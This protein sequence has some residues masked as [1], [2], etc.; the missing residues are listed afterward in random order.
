MLAYI[1]TMHGMSMKEAT[2]VK[3]RTFSKIWH[4][5]N[6]NNTGT[7][8]QECNLTQVFANCSNEE[9]NFPLTTLKIADTQKTNAKLKHC[10]KCN[11]IID[12]GLEVILV[13]D[14]YVSHRPWHIGRKHS[15]LNV[16]I[17]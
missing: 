12:K 17:C 14:K 5:H 1:V 16:T 11:V 15:L 9:E 4:C 2:T 10:F 13:E 8:T 3:W 7:H 6:E